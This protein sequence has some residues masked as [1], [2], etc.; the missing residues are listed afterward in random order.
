MLQ[1]V[2]AQNKLKPN[3]VFGLLVTTIKH[4]YTDMQAWF[5]S[6]NLPANFS[7]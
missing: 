7:E 6:P 2:T 4:T 3:I 1:L 5:Y